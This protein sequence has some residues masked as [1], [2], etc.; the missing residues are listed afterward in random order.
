MELVLPYDLFGLYK[1]IDKQS[2]SMALTW[3]LILDEISCPHNNKWWN[4]LRSWQ[5]GGGYGGW[6]IR[7]KRQVRK[8]WNWEG[9]FVNWESYQILFISKIFGFN[10]ILGWR[11][12]TAQVSYGHNGSGSDSCQVYIFQSQNITN[13]FCRWYFVI[14][15]QGLKI[16]SLWK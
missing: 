14:C 8:T 15:L 13:N 1:D 16:S 12:R 4:W 5:P 9:F 10:E 3:V 2:C 11:P 6:V 7:K